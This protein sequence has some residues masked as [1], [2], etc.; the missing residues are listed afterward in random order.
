[1]KYIKRFVLTVAGAILV[2]GQSFAGNPER[3]GSAGATELL[4]NPFARSAGWADVNLG[5]VRGS[6]AM[7][8][9]IAGLAFVTK[10]EIDFSNT[11]WLVNS[12]IQINSLTFAQRVGENGV[13]GIGLVSFDYGEWEITTEHQ[14]LGT[15]GVISPS[16]L[17]INVGYSAKFTES[18]YGGVNIKAYNNSVSNMKTMGMCFDAGVQYIP[19]SNDSWKFGVTL[20]NVGPS[21]KYKGDGMSVV[22]SVP[23]FGVPYNMSYESKSA[24]YELPVQLAMGLSYDF[25]LAENHNLVGAVAFTSNSFEKDFFQLGAEYN[26]KNVFMVRMGYKAYTSNEEAGKSALTGLTGGFTAQIPTNK[27]EGTYLGLSYSYRT[28]NP[29]QGVHSVGLN[30]GF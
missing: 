15:A 7:F 6:D 2:I 11:Q 16:S 9:N 26:F 4:I 19:E 20:K 24:S 3:S 5:G 21:L 12:G 13:L 10:T 30:V 8:V 23:T 18:I 28:T 29:F 27:E 17:I 14:P 25:R 1:M 22:L